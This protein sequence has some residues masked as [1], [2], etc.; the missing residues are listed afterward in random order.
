VSVDAGDGVVEV[1][2][3]EYERL[4]EAAGQADEYGAQ[5]AEITRLGTFAEAGFDLDNPTDQLFIKGYDGD[6]SIEAIHAAAQ[7]AG[8]EFEPVEQG[9]ESWDSSES[10]PEGEQGIGA[11]SM[12]EALEEAARAAKNQDD[13]NE[14]IT[15]VYRAYGE[16]VAS[17]ME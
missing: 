13:L 9:G 15:E 14:R 2:A 8:W 10:G 12:R 16:V 5:I 3:E 6:M 7:E 4:R 11:S 17:D 1:S